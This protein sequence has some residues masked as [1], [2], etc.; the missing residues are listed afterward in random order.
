MGN[1]AIL[2]RFLKIVALAAVVLTASRLVFFVNDPQSF[3]PTGWNNIGLAFLHGVRFDLVTI[4][5]G[6]IPIWAWLLISPSKWPKAFYWTFLLILGLATFA[7]AIDTEFFKFTAKRMTSDIFRFIFMSD[8]VFHI[9]FEILFSFWYLVLSWCIINGFA[10]WVVIKKAW[11]GGSVKKSW[12]RFALVPI[13]I[14]LVVLMMRGGVQKYPLGIHHSLKIGDPA[15]STLVL[16]SPFTFIKTLGKKPLIRPSFMDHEAAK[17]LYNPVVSLPVDSVFGSR[18][19]KNVVILMVESLGKEYIGSLNKLESGYTPFID[20]LVNEGLILSNAFA[21]GHRSIDGI[22]A[23]LS[24]FPSMMY[25][26]LGTS[27][28]GTN[29]HD[30]IADLVRDIGYSTSFF[31]GGNEGTMGFESFTRAAGFEEYYDR[32]DYPDQAHYDGQWGIFDHYFLDYTADKISTFSEPFLSTIFTL[33]SH[34]PYSIPE[35][36]TA[37]FP[38]GELD[39]H[40]SIGYADHSLRLFFENAKSQPWYDN[41]LFVITADHTSLTQGGY[42]QNY[43]GKLAVPILFFS[44]KGKDLRGEFNQVSAQVDIMPSIL[45]LL[46]FERPFVSFGRSIFDTR[47]PNLSVTFTKH[48]FQIIQDDM[49]LRFDG[50]ESTSLYN[51]KIDSLM[52][53]DLLAQELGKADSLSLLLKSYIQQYSE[54]MYNNRMTDIDD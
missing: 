23:T 26:P 15:N 45:H 47:A 8:D 46:G 43:A 14:G 36:Y 50:A 42:Y 5:Y 22:P 1:L 7:N 3:L 30:G 21:N 28:F 10:Y 17:A 24:S 19:G 32:A 31:H 27:S 25:E 49:L 54:R 34:H 53:N 39:I 12:G 38:K 20:S 13:I 6:F 41:T 52:Q 48:Q 37:K 40:E 2:N 18:K 16:N 11:I 35:Q 44:P 4:A 29:V 9:G 51:L 33:S